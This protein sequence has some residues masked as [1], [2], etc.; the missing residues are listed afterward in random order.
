MTLT[1]ILLLNLL[2]IGGYMLMK[3]GLANAVPPERL[4]A[5]G[6]LYHWSAMVLLAVGW[7]AALIRGGW[8][9]GSATGDLK[10]IGRPL[11]TY[12][13]MA[14]LSVWAWN[15][16]VAKDA[17]ALKVAL[18]RAQ[19]LEHTE[20]DEAYAA[21]LADA[22]LEGTA[23]ER[24]QFKEQALEQ[25]EWMNGPALTLAMALIVYLAAGS[26]LTGLAVLVLHKIWNIASL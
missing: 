6:G 19:V 15:H 14:S 1:R 18:Q 21:F 10:A 26:L 8:S 25:I 2:L 3:A 22:D 16:V 13:V 4:V 20:N 11:M 12:A 17:T 23:P 5:L 7:S 24:E 9:S